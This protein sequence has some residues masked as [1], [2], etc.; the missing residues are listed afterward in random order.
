[1]A[2]LPF[3]T[4]KLP[5]PRHVVTVCWYEGYDAHVHTKDFRALTEE[6]ALAKAEQWEGTYLPRYVERKHVHSVTVPDQEAA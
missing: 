3:R 2:A 4:P 5:I 6:A 1:M